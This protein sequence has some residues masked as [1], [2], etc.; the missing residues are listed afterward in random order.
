MSDKFGLMMLERV[1]DQYLNGNKVL[2][3]ADET[4]AA[5]D[6]EVK[7]LLAKAYEEAKALLDN[8]RDLLDKMAEYLLEKE[9]ITGKQFMEIFRTKYPEENKKDAEDNQD[10]EEGIQDIEF[11]DSDAEVSE[12]ED[13]YSDSESGN[14]IDDCVQ[15]FDKRV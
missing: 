10:S 7:A 8:N 5:I 3:C 14:S 13:T 6:A 4:A 15:V 11:E 9:S 1:Q 2:E 12:A